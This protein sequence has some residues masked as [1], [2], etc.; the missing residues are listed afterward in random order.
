[1]L[2]SLARCVVSSD[3]FDQE[4]EKD[5]VTFV[6]HL[7]DAKRGAS[8][9]FYSP[10]Q[11]AAGCDI[12]IVALRAL[13]ADFFGFL[14]QPFRII[15]FQLIV[16]VTQLVCGVPD[17]THAPPHALDDLEGNGFNGLKK[18]LSEFS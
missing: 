18:I 13:R 16:G 12:L 8:L 4:T 3:V 6:A 17:A 9:K 15:S 1:M 7:C 5:A 11:P 2:F 10:S 14:Q